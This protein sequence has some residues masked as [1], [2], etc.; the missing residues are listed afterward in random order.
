MNR[1]AVL[2]ISAVLIAVDISFTAAV[3]NAGARQLTATLEGVAAIFALVDDL[4][5]PFPKLGELP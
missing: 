3:F 4:V 1:K 5:R 2:T